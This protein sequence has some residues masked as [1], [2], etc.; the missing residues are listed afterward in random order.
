MIVHL[1][2]ADDET[3]MVDV[4][5]GH[6]QKH[7]SSV[8]DVKVDLSAQKSSFLSASI[9][10]Y[11]ENA[12]DDDQE[13]GEV[14]N[15]EIPRPW[16]SRCHG[17]ACRCG[18]HALVEDAGDDDEHREEDNLQEQASEDDVVSK[19]D[20]IL[21]AR[22]R[23][24]TTTFKVVSQLEAEESGDQGCTH[25]LTAQKRTG[26]RRRRRSSSTRRV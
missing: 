13:T 5:D 26:H 22:T 10:G 1:A 15:P 2:F 3:G 9:L 16:E 21:I 23:E 7:Q 6:D 4:E 11:A 8:K 25:H 14:E 17:I 24:H 18:V 12:S 19:L 20:G